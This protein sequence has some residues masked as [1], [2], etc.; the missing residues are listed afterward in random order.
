MAV[1]EVDDFY[2]LKNTKNE[3]DFI[4]YFWENLKAEQTQQKI[5]LP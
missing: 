5:V 2:G 3:S 4:K 1:H